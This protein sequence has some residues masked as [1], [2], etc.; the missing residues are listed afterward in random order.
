LGFFHGGLTLQEWIIPVVT[1]RFPQKAQKLGGVLK[2]ISQIISLAQRVQVG[3]HATQL[4]LLS[5]Q[6]H[7][8]YLS[9][10]VM[11]KVIHPAT[12]KVIL[13]SKQQVILE[14]G[15]DLVTLEL[16]VV[17]GA[18]AALKS[19]LELRLLDADDE[20]LLDHTKVTLQIELDE[21]A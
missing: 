2:P 13:K 16:M 20:E 18:T 8:N 21:W 1:I 5:G 3:S 15:G 11:I 17:P 14:P 4:D 9:R 10:P 12:G 19:E 6:A 7:E